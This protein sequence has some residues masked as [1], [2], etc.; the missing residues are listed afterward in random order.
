MTVKLRKNEA[1]STDDLNVYDQFDVK[2]YEGDSDGVKR[3]SLVP[4]S[5]TVTEAFLTDFKNALN[6]DRQGAIDSHTANLA[7]IDVDIALIDEKIAAILVLE[8]R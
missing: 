3:D 1:D 2:N 5:G 8:G 4:L 6:A 7:Q